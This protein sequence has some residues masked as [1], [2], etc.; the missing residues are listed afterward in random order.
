MDG[1]QTNELTRR[2]RQAVASGDLARA[3]TLWAE[4][5]TR[6]G[7][8]GRIS[9]GEVAEARELA[10]WTRTMALSARAFAR[11]RLARVTVAQH[12][13]VPMGRQPSRLALRG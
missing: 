8:G 10:A 13:G 6:F 12:Y 7:D 3:R 9:S 11:D 5:G 1:D 2:I 4:Y